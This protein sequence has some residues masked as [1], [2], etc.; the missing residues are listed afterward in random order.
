MN[1]DLQQFV[2]ES[3]QRGIPRDQI[4]E[5]LANAGW[6]AEEVEAALSEWIDSTFPVPVPRRRPYLSAHEAFLY[7]V[8]FVTL[9]VTAFNVGALLFQFVERWMPDPATRGRY[10]PDRF[11]PQGVR[12]AVAGLAIAYPVYLLLSRFI[13]RMLA[14]DPDKRGSRVRKWLTYVTLFL[15]ALV[16]LGDLIVLVAKLL[17]G[18][19]PPRFIA[20]AAIVLA[21]ALFVFTHY[22]SE[23]R[24][25]EGERDRG[26]VQPGWITRLAGAAVVIVIAIG[27]F[28]A[29]SPQ[30]AR[31][32]ELD[33]QRV[34]DLQQ[35]SAAV[36][37]YYRDRR[38]LPSSLDAVFRLPSV[39]VESIQ[40]PLTRGMYEYRI[41]D[42]T[43]YELCAGFDRTDTT[44]TNLDSYPSR[45]PRFWRHPA[46]RFCYVLET[47]RSLVE[48]I[49]T[50]P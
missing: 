40:D 23:L 20:K 15:A 37:G 5:Q 6:R 35:I 13:G 30:V 47:P 34:R 28:V 22:L 49:R 42:S 14:R 48:G 31:M 8:L 44:D 19:L 11:S 50:V 38:S 46:G 29:G 2:R 9:Y 17:S 36:D 43:T 41:V 33:R 7:L 16:I 1:A 27:L 18:E 25:D 45:T 24:R 3:L 26:P 39:P 32:Q 4:R 21:I 10:T 12:D